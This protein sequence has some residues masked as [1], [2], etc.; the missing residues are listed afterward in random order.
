MRTLRTIPIIDG[1]PL[2]GEVGIKFRH[3][4]FVPE[5]ADPTDPSLKR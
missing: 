2:I 1:A 4:K 5:E 3:H